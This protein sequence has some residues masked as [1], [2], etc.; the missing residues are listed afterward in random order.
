MESTKHT[1]NR[2]HNLW[3]CRL[4]NLPIAQCI[5][6][7]ICQYAECRT[8]QSNRVQ[9]LPITQS[10]YCGIWKSVEW[11][12]CQSLDCRLSIYGLCNWQIPQSTD[13]QIPHPTDS[14]ILQSMDSVLG[15]YHPLGID[16]FLNLWVVCG[17]CWLHWRICQ[18]VYYGIII[19]FI[20]WCICESIDWGICQSVEWKSANCTIH[21]LEYYTIDRIGQ[22][23]YQ[24]QNWN[25]SFQCMHFQ[26]V[27]AICF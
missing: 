8:C 22:F 10:V 26:V 20:D 14:Q 16:K 12:I 13:C 25:L 17:I 18:S 27:G 19:Q 15:G 24:N 23:W 3:I 1:I 5:Y 21:R 9:N 11:G 2:L 6:W 4:R 7:R